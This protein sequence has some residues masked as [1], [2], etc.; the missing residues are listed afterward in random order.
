MIITVP[1]CDFAGYY[2]P[3][4]LREL[5]ID[6]RSRR[7]ELGLTDENMFEVHVQL[8]R[9]FSTV[10]H[11]N[12]ARLDT[13][14]SELL[15]GSAKLRE[16]IRQLLKLIGIKLNS[17]SPAVAGILLKLSEVTHS[18]IT[19]FLPEFS[20]FS[21]DAT[22]PIPFEYLE[23]GGLTLHRTD[24]AS[25]VYGAE[26]VKA[27]T[28]SVDITTPD[29]I[30]RTAGSVFAAGDVGNH[31][32]IAEGTRSNGGEFRIT[33][34][35]NVNQVRVVRIPGSTAPAF[36]SEI[37]LAWTMI[38][39]TAD[40]AVNAYTPG[41][42]F[43]PWATPD[44][45]DCLYIGH[46][47]ALFDNIKI[48]L[49][50][51]GAALVINGCF[52]YFDNQASRFNPLTVTDNGDGTI[53][54]NVNPL[55]GSVDRR[56]AEVY[57]ECLLT[58]SRER[59]T[60]TY[61]SNNRITTSSTLG[62]TV[63]STD[64]EDYIITTDWVPLENQSDGSTN[65]TV[66]GEITYNLPQNLERNW[67]KTDVNLQE[68]YWIRYRIVSVGGAPASPSIDLVQIDQG[69]QYLFVM[70]TQ[71]E[72]VGPI[73]IGSSNGSASQQFTL[74]DSPFIDN[75]DEIE[76]DETGLGVWVTYNRVANFLLSG[77]TSR[78]YTIDTNNA[79]EAVI[80]FGNGTNG[81]IPPI[82]ASN[83][84][85][86]FRIGADDNGNIGAN[87]ITTNA[88]GVNGISEVTNPRGAAG[89]RQKDGA[90]E[91]DIER[92]KRDKPA[93]MRTRE[94]AANE[95]DTLRLAINSFVD[96]AGSKAIAR[97]YA[98]EEGYGPKTVKLLVVG[99]GGIAL[100]T[101]Q[102]ADAET[103]FNGNRYTRPPVKGRLIL[104]HRLYAC[105]F[106]PRLISVVATVVWPGG[107]ANSVQTALLNLLTPLA[108]E[109]DGVNYVWDFGGTINIS[110]VY[111]AI[112]AVNNNVIGVP[113]LLLNGVAGSLSM[114]DN[115]L[116]I[117]TAASVSIN[118]QQTI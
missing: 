40:Y 42:V 116:P 13:V 90:T 77:E 82:G 46:D 103:Y 107:N 54:L 55:L 37:G 91:A 113:T 96:S 80:T 75:T 117:T 18:D 97:A 50:A 102:L 76:V 100:S 56:G 5:L 79:D 32:L 105:N 41:D 36:V 94:T 64:I 24:R 19:E 43:S 98:V 78:H 49:G 23:D 33:Q 11:M 74:P 62:Q 81:K 106:V 71:G 17:A 101:S 44:V 22:P 93:E 110:R 34:F 4:I 29:I 104:N 67:T 118:I 73:V 68:A 26:A 48:T 21:T 9:A 20:T 65:F 12:N 61:S 108:M 14:A 86:T 15:I 60:S 59:I 3:E 70:A 39:F 1:S 84:R 8:L 87:T 28:A 72:T 69:N 57:V 2:Y 83:I 45:G 6:L 99:Q 89:W 47:E 109:E 58:G 35:L 10:G 66:D 92:L 88:D 51:G 31:I 85:A 52:E 38:Q 7:E 27:G 111:A 53:T 114:S 30:T 25:H 63:I 95:D 112:H 16:S 115:Q